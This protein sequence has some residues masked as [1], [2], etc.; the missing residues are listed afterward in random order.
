MDIG[1]AFVD[2]W[3]T[4]TKN[5]IVIILAAIVSSILWYLIVPMVGFQMMFVKA[6]RGEGVSFNEVFSS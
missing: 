6:K 1:K 4:Y 5:L 3:N 2:A